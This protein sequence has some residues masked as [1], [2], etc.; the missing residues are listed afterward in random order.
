MA[1]P[2]SALTDFLASLV[3][4]PP[5]DLLKR[6]TEG[7]VVTSLA[8]SAQAAGLAEAAAFPDDRLALHTLFNLALDGGLACWVADYV[9]LV[10]CDRSLTSDD[11]TECY[12]L[13]G[14]CVLKWAQAAL[15]RAN[16]Q[17][18]DVLRAPAQF[19]QLHLNSAWLQGSLCRV[20]GLLLVLKALER[21]AKLD[22]APVHAALPPSAGQASAAGAQPQRAVEVRAGSTCTA[23]TALHCWA[24]HAKNG[25]DEER[26]M[27]YLQRYFIIAST[28][29]SYNGPA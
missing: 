1:A 13:G 12:L 19:A 11:P 14:D 9:E 23:C 16:N 7:R 8:R 20:N 25:R 6:G 18:R 24:M 22:A 28:C 3:A 29:G 10:C 27:L 17:L 2:R 15:S 21:E 26:A 5:R 4:V